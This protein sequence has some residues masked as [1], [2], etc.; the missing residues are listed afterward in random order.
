MRQIPRCIGLSAVAPPGTAGD[1]PSLAPTILKGGPSMNRL[2]ARSVL[3]LLVLFTLAGF[4]KNKKKEEG[5][6][7]EARLAQIKKIAVASVYG[8]RELHEGLKDSTL[9]QELYDQLEADLLARLQTASLEVL[10][11]EQTKA[12]LA[13]EYAQAYVEALPDKQKKQAEKLRPAID[14][15]Y[16][17]FP[18]ASSRGTHVLFGSAVSF[19]NT[20]HR[21]HANAG[22]ETYSQ[23][24]AEYDE[25]FI[26]T[27]SGL[28]RKLGADGFLVLRVIPDM[29][30]TVAKKSAIPGLDGIRAIRAMKEGDH[31][32]LT[33]DLALY[34]S[35]GQ[36]AFAD[37]VTVMSESAVG[38]GGGFTAV[39]GYKEEDVKRLIQEAVP[40][41]MQGIFDRLAGRDAEKAK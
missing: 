23:P 9:Q 18:I 11:L 28:T 37:Q 13:A 16:T 25:V 14:R 41:A 4:G 36:A 40:S 17:F 31:A 35:D 39:K 29:A 10:P 32:F 22:K 26:Q 5:L 21:T 33:L 3:A 19:E 30:T 34:T 24:R 2:V 6:R 1:A 7:D 8:P 38:V 15:G 27:L 20:E 12:L